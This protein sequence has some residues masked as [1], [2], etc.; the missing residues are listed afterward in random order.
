MIILKTPQEIKTMAKAG[1]ILREIIQEISQFIQPGL[2][3]YDIEEKVN[4]LFKKAKVKSSFLNYHGF[5]SKICTSVNDQ[6]VHGIPNK[7]VKIKTGDLVGIDIGIKYQGYNVDAAVTIPIEPIKP[8]HRKLIATTRRAL[9]KAIQEVRPNNYLSNIGATIQETIEKAGFEVVKECS[10][11]GIGRELHEDPTVLNFG[12]RNEGI[13]LKPGMTFAI[14]PMAVEG[15]AV[16]K[17][18]NDGWT[19]STVDG[20]YSAHFEKTVAVTRKGCQI[21]T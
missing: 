16:M 9:E 12:K 4:Q 3:T 10:G 8:I 6:I 18:E 7:K 20:G 14:E 13:I 2:S 11:H 21:L 15:K 17:I 5:P 1:Q 19:I